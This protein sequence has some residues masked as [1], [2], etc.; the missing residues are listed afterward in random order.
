[1]SKKDKSFEFGDAFNFSL[2]NKYS[3]LEIVRKISEIYGKESE[4]ETIGGGHPL[5][6]SS[7]LPNVKLDCEKARVKLNWK[8]NFSIEEGIKES[9]DFYKSFFN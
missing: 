6:G 1:M 3:V 5:Y 9:V 4:I 2:E 8:P 7:E